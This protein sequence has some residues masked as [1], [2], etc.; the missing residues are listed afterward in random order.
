[1]GKIGAAYARNFIRG[2]FDPTDRLAVVLVN[3]RAT[4]V[5]QR[6]AT[7]ERIGRPDFLAW[8]GHKNEEG[9]EVYIS[10]NSLRPDARGRTK[11]DVGLIRHVFLD[12][13]E[14]GTAA[15]RSL[16]QRQDLPTPSLV[17]NTSPGKWQVNWQVE[18]L[19][20]E[21]AETLQKGLARQLGADPAATDCSRVLRFP[22]FD[23]HKYDRPYLV[24][25]EPHAAL[26]GIRYKLSD[27]PDFPVPRP[28]QDQVLVVPPAPVPKSGGL[29]QSE[30]D[31]AYAR[32][33]LARGE[34]PELVAAAIANYRRSDK[35]D[36][37]YYAELTVRK[38]AE[39]L[40][41][42]KSQSF[43]LERS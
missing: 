40:A 2:S 9:Y 43:G 41:A 8:I 23:N 24:R 7:A 34:T 25:A 38:A 11:A 31:W 37:R 39:S 20:K 16:F 36:P 4:S 19:A 15:V 14:N 27:F 5:I 21:E 32:R 6:L 22:G 29:S 13:D 28:F 17:V 35:H 1:M 3:K 26:A 10:M 42:D 18:G 33:A 30:R 12:F